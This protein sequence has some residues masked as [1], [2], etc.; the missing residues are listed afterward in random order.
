MTQKSWGWDGGCLL[1]D[2]FYMFF[3]GHYKDK[4]SSDDDYQAAVDAA[5]AGKYSMR[6]FDSEQYRDCFVD[7]SNTLELE[8]PLNRERFEV[9]KYVF[10][11]YFRIDRAFGILHTTINEDESCKPVFSHDSDGEIAMLKKAGISNGIWWHLQNLCMF[12]QTYLEKA[13]ENIVETCHCL[14]IDSDPLIKA[15]ILQKEII[16]D[17]ARKRQMQEVPKWTEHG[18]R[19][20]SDGEK[21]IVRNAEAALL[22]VDVALK[23]KQ[24]QPN[25]GQ[26]QDGDSLSTGQENQSPA[27]RS[28]GRPQ[29]GGVKINS[30]LIEYFGRNPDAK[31]WTAKELALAIECSA[32]AIKQTD[33]WKMIQEDR[34]KERETRKLIKGAVA[35]KELRNMDG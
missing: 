17:H 14:E 3:A 8:N 23:T 13:V 16:V 6:W 28:K 10:E 26:G 22:R 25:G 33:M 12:S 9:S 34:K 15:M 27:T 2:L 20:L 18:K 7:F 21:D 19:F 35:L 4:S 29:K 24:G 1:H 30:Q 11:Y 5:K 32:S 31:N